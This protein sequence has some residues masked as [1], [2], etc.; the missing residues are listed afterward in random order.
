MVDPMPKHAPTAEGRREPTREEDQRL[1][2]AI[3]TLLRI[4]VMIAAAL[5][6]IGGVMALRSPS[7]Q[8]RTFGSS[9]HPSTPQPPLPRAQPS[10]PSPPSSI[11]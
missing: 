1:E 3:A 8:F 2:V 10:T 7:R 11:S 9:T 4:G 6:A 5:V